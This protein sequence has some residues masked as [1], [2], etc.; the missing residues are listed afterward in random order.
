MD[1][2]KQNSPLVCWL[3]CPIS[4]QPQQSNHLGDILILLNPSEKSIP[5]VFPKD[6]RLLNWQLF[7]DTAKQPPND[8]FPSLIESN[9]NPASPNPSNPNPNR[10]AQSITRLLNRSMMVFIEKR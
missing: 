8:I 9:P 4:K 2:S 10:H 7:L 6:S 3:T 1:W 5:F